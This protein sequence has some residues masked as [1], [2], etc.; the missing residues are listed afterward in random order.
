MLDVN[1]SPMIP[2][3]QAHRGLVADCTLDH[4]LMQLPIQV[5]QG[6]THPAVDDGHAAGVWAG[7]G[8]VGRR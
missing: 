8:C 6:L 7:D 1:E 3:Q 5:D 4:M 2:Y